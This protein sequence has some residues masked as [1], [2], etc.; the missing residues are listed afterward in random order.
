MKRTL[1]LVAV[2]V[3]TLGMTA[4]PALAAG[5]HDDHGHV[6][7]LHA[8]YDPNPNF[9]P[10]DPESGPPYFLRGFGKCV[11]ISNGRAHPLHVHH[12]TIHQ[13]RAGEALRGA[14]HLTVPLSPMTD[15]EGCADLEEAFSNSPT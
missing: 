13:G 11:D 7:L 1:T 3:M 14:G 2:L 6:L 9:D 10:Q 8:D 15:F 5:H 12:D 4:M